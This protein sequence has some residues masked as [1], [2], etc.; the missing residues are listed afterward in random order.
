MH[1]WPLS[2]IYSFYNEKVKV[3]SKECDY[4]LSLFIVT[5]NGHGDGSVYTELITKKNKYIHVFIVVWKN[6]YDSRV[7]I[8]N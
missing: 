6:I 7:K 4:I 1:F 3:M 5:L 8:S 2:K